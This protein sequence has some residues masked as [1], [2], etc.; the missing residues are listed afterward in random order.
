MSKFK[1]GQKVR[2][3]SYEELRRIGTRANIRVDS[4]FSY[5]N[6]VFTVALVT[7]LGN[8]GLDD[9]WLICHDTKLV[10]HED[11]LQSAYELDEKFKEL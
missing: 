5:S 9:W 8:Y 2:F 7:P 4:H 10:F 6:K 3:K 1:V 11:F